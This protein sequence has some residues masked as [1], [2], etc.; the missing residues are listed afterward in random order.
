MD[1]GKYGNNNFLR[2]KSTNHLPLLPLLVLGPAFGSACLFATGFLELLR[3]LHRYSDIFDPFLS[4]F[5]TSKLKNTR[6][7]C[8]LSDFQFFFSVIIYTFNAH[9][10][11]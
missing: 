3:N 2:R 4:S 6:Y 1:D 5:G 10:R 7:K 8:F 11:S 9:S